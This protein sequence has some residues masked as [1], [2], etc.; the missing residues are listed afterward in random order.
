MRYFILFLM[1]FTAFVHAVEIPDSMMTDAQKAYI[2]SKNI[3]VTAK[4]Q[5]EAAHQYI[6]IGREL[7]EAVNASLSAITD[8]SNKFANTRVG[9]FTTLIIF[10]KVCGS[11]VKGLLMIVIM[12]TAYILGA[13]ASYFTYA[14]SEENRKIPDSSSELSEHINVKVDDI[15][16]R[17]AWAFCFLVLGIIAMMMTVIIGIMM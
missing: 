5:A 8:Q 3:A 15:T 2:N 4:T 17:D 12:W 10:Y 9:K 16:R 13:T 11:L 7:G 14:R 6:G 1:V